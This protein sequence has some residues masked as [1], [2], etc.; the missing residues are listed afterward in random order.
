MNSDWKMQPTSAI[1]KGKFLKVK[2]VIVPKTIV[3]FF[4][5]GKDKTNCDISEVAKKSDFLFGDPL[6]LNSIRGIYKYHL[7]S[8]RRIP[9][10]I[11][12][13]WKFVQVNDKFY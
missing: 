2:E 11:C 10:T 8:R 12:P 6:D 9:A 5:L 4:F 7:I 1:V 3:I 13:S